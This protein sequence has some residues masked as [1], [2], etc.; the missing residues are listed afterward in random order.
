M[1]RFI[2]FPSPLARSL[3]AAILA[4]GIACLLIVLPIAAQTKPTAPITLDG[5][6]LFKVSDSGGYSA[7]Q[8]AEDAN[9]LLQ[10]TVKTAE[11]PVPV[12]VVESNDLPVIQLNGNYL[13]TVTQDD[14]PPGVSAKEQAK[15]WAE[16]LKTSIEQ[17]QQERSA[18]YI[19]NALLLSVGCVLLA[20]ACG[21][22]VGW[23]WRYWLRPLLPREVT[24]S[25]TPKQ[26]TGVEQGARF[27]IVAI[28]TLLWLGTA[29][30]IAN[31]FPQTRVWSRSV[32]D[33]LVFTLAS[34]MVPL[35][36]KSYSLMQ[37][38]LLIGLFVGL[39]VLART[40]KKLLRSRVLGMTGMSRGAQET[41]ALIANYALIFIGTLVLLQVWGL[42][43]S[44]LT[45]FA[46]VLG[47][48]IGLGLQ[49]IAKEFVS[50][51][52]IIFE[53]PI[54]VGDFVDVGGL[55]GTVERISVRST[56]IR[57]LDRVAIFVP[58]SRFLES[59]VLNWSYP[60]PISRLKVPVRVAYGSNLSSMRGALID[61]AKEHQDILS[62]PAPQ[63]L[64][65]E[66][67]ESS[68]QFDLLVWI[69]EPS[70]QF[71]IKS[72]LYFRID[73]L[74]RDRHLEIPLPQRELHFRNG[75]L[76]LELSP[77]LQDSLV[78]LSNGLSIWLKHQANQVPQDS[79]NGTNSTEPPSQQPNN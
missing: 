72:D 24:D 3:Q 22:G 73:T 29:I 49:G 57:T 38:I 61:A 71:Q 79:Y 2:R 8:R 75:G 65:R 26:Q 42:D 74:L 47:V 51:L 69:A 21:W 46:G 12:Q 66:F 55:V 15:A 63:V 32:T 16:L 19:H 58:N 33:V 27:L 4:L 59:E 36:E 18:A 23:I 9:R 76:P 53:R 64:F 28:R 11:P 20:L 1:N 62:E 13:L 50:G 31:L 37:L 70:K 35:G 34:P 44:S 6:H 60:S 39:L 45:I 17:A 67:G 41:V 77:Q 56:E 14:A 7:Q 43:L 54:Q 68:L 78:Q 48:G 52:V 25:Q 5:R 40:A 10:Q 30:Y